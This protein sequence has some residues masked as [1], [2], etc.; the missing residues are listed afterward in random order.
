VV[1]ANILISV[2]LSGTSRHGRSCCWHAA[3]RLA[4]FKPEIF[5]ESRS[6]QGLL[7]LAEAGHGVAIV[8][9]V[10]PTHRYLPRFAVPFRSNHGS[11]S[12]S[13]SVLQ[14][15]P[16]GSRPNIDRGP[17]SVR[18]PNRKSAP[19]NLGTYSGEARSHLSQVEF[20]STF[21]GPIVSVPVRFNA[22]KLPLRVLL[23]AAPARDS[24][25]ADLADRIARNRDAA[26]TPCG[27][28][29]Q[30]RCVSPQATICA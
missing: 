28:T 8:S 11:P 27:R 14:H 4:G 3:C 6:P 1:E 15:N 5:V 10:L 7:T 17:C 23:A 22:L 13:T 26:V 30:D 25:L 21:G 24:D 9:S 19:R 20:T 12:P 2:P 18:D 16:Q 29:V